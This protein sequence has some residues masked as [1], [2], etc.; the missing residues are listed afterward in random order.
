MRGH[1]VMRSKDGGRWDEYHLELADGT[2]P[3][4]VYESGLWK[5]FA[6][7]EPTAS[8]NARDAG[9]V[10]VGEEITVG[11]FSA[12]VTY[13][14]ASRVVYIQG[15][16]PEGYR[17]GSEADYFNAVAGSDMLVVSWT[18]EEVEYYRGRLLPR[19][20]VEHAFRLPE[21]SLL[22]RFWAG[23][24]GFDSW[25]ESAARL[26]GT[27][28]V[29]L[30]F[31]A[32]LV[33]KERTPTGG[34]AAPPPPVAPSAARLPLRAQG[35]LLGRL[36]ALS[37]HQ[38]VD[39]AD[40]AGRFGRHEYDLID[41]QGG[42]ALLVQALDRNPHQWTL[43]AYQ[44][45]PSPMRP[46]EAA[47]YAAGSRINVA[48]TDAIVRQLFIYRTLA[49]DGDVPASEHIG[50]IRYGFVAETKDGSL[51]ARWSA[52]EIETFLGAP[53]PEAQVLDA[54]GPLQSP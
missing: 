27:V 7:F 26:G 44:A 36:Y 21:P 31:I 42:R 9:E 34:T 15:R 28:V 14:G 23:S 46:V 1:S 49:L 53:V 30:I 19:G 5:R 22:S 2:A 24:G 41:D 33:A 12:K 54:L 47:A 37:G 43:F 48:G 4:L 45:G 25:F 11:G 18:G 38:L 3:T 6:L 32:I 35:R 29:F 8:L 17:I 52:T 39:V 13:V 40:P 51:L 20:T 16:A 50:G 10:S